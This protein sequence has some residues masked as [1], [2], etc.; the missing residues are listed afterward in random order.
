LNRQSAK[1]N[2]HEEV[3][4]S[5]NVKADRT[6]RLGAL[7][8]LVAIAS[9]NITVAGQM[10]TSATA[11][12]PHYRMVVLGT[13]GG[14]NGGPTAPAASLNNRGDVIAQASTAT[15]DPDPISFPNGDGLIWHG[16]LSNATGIVRDLGALP[17]TNSSVPQGISQNGLI[18]G[19]SENGLLDPLTNFPQMRAVLWDHNLRIVDL[20]TLGGYASNGNAVNSRGQVV[21]AAL[22]AVP[23]DP[24]IAGIFNGTGIFSGL[25][26]AQQ[27]R[28]F[29][30]QGGV[31]HDLGTL[32]GNNAQATFINEQGDVTGFSGTNNDDAINDAT[33]SP[34]IHPFLWKNGRMQD[35]GSLGGT[36]ATPGSFIYGPWGP[37]MNAR[38]DVA[39]TSYLPGDTSWHAFLWSHGHM[40]DLGTLGGSKS[41]A[42]SINDR[43]QVVGRA[44]VT[45]TPLV[46]HAFLWE[47]GTM[48]DLGT[49][50]QCRGTA[51]GVNSKGQ[52]VGGLTC[53]D[54]SGDFNDFRP[55]YVEKGKPMVDL[56]TLVDPPSD[57]YMDDAFL[58]NERGEIYAPAFTST[59]ES[60]A[61][62]LVPL[63]PSDE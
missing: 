11:K 63:P 27:V 10:D 61:V 39:G 30:W 22:N 55:F 42:V 43:G 54:N 51:K 18:S 7:A 1:N 9:P 17:G 16:I 48:T 57:L 45:D 52:I 50:D 35:L 25:P 26:A 32:G 58:I 4:M 59:G 12:Y 5:S 62:L 37:V 36:L 46:R 40:I 29:L 21:G 2:P 20:G 28:A 41:E 53:P 8:L 60:R 33:G 3:V 31:M 47:N 14:P 23:E 15:P 13:L 6:A 24:D 34:T 19:V 38:G 49:I 56:N 44:Y